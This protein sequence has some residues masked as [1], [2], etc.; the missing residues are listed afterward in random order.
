MLKYLEK[1]LV[2][3]TLLAV[4]L[5]IS[6]SSKAGGPPFTPISFWPSTFIKSADMNTNFQNIANAFATT[7]SA[8]GTQCATHL[9]HSGEL[10]SRREG[11]IDCNHRHRHRR[12]G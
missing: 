8:I 12:L 1:W 9:G 3:A 6:F 11:R 10:R 4:G 5:T 7:Q 2:G